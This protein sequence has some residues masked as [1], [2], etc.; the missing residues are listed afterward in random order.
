MLTYERIRRGGFNKI[1]WNWSKAEDCEESVYLTKEGSYITEDTCGL[2]S[3]DPMV[4]RL[5]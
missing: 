1:A 4:L 5:V 3:G 2:E